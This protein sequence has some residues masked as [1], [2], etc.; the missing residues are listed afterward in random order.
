M[1]YT[2]PRE[3][4]ERI[5]KL[6][7][8]VDKV[9]CHVPYTGGDWERDYDGPPEDISPGLILVGDRGVYLM[10]NIQDGANFKDLVFDSNSDGFR[11][12]C[13]YAAECNPNTMAF[14]SWWSS[15][16]AGFGPDDGCEFLAMPNV[17]SW[18]EA[19]RESDV[20][21]MDVTPKSIVLVEPQNTKRNDPELDAIQEASQRGI[22]I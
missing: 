4:I 21:T 14:D 1:R 6:F 19:N 13:V 22:R 10:T 20:L 8:E 16:Q 11:K 17:R 5:F 18:M 3:E 15:K 7:D 9:R 12:D 2:F